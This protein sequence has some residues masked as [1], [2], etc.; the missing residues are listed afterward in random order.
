M[1]WMAHGSMPEGSSTAEGLQTMAQTIDFSSVSSDPRALKIM[2]KSLYRELRGRGYKE[3]DVLSFAG[4]LLSLVS[5]E[6]RE[7]NNPTGEPGKLPL[8]RVMRRKIPGRLLRN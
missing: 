3:G 8:I 1:A 6:V 7:R 2:A 5:S 4:E